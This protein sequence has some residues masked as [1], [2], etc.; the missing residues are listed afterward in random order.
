MAASEQS[1]NAAVERAN[2]SGWAIAKVRHSLNFLV[3]T[4]KWSLL[5]DSQVEKEGK[6]NRGQII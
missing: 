5:F 2:R 3:D 6:L 1:K 4:V